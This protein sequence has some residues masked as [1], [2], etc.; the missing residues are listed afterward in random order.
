MKP[1]Q[2]FLL[3]NK[4]TEQP[5]FSFRVPETVEADLTDCY[6]HVVESYGRV[7]EPSTETMRVIRSVANWFKNG[8]TGLL[9][10]GKCG[11]GKSIML[12]SITLLIRHYYSDR[13][14]VIV[15]SAPEVCEL[16]RENKDD[17]FGRLKKYRY[18]GL[19]DL[20]TESLIVKRW[21]TELSPVLD[22]LYSRYDNRKV[23]VITTND[24]LEVIKN[25]YG[26]RLYDRL[27]EI[28]D[29]IPFDFKSFRQN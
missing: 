16:S 15:F 11:T 26:E 21:G 22:V 24:S 17:D 14:N 3:E 5:R 18:L 2:E 19:D 7:F 10:S 8:K 9:L 6:R 29:R 4:A 12:K 27:C 25:K 20:G 23:T 1:I 28:Y 13:M